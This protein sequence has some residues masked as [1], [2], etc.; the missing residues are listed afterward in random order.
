M[1]RYAAGTAVSLLRWIYS[2]HL[3]FQNYLE[4]FKNSVEAAGANHVQTGWAG[5]PYRLYQ[6]ILVNKDET[7]K[8]RFQHAQTLTQRLMLLNDVLQ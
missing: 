7:I 3:K 4:W 1:L 2:D 5:M 8:R 6:W